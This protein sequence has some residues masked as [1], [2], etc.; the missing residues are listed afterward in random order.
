MKTQASEDEGKRIL[1]QGNGM[2]QGH[3][4]GERFPV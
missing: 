3:E 4:A 2:F 1:G